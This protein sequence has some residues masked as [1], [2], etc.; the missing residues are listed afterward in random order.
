VSLLAAEAFDF[1][2]RHP[3]DTGFGERLLHFFQFERLYDRLDH[4]HKS[5]FVFDAA[6][7]T[8]P[9]VYALKPLEQPGCQNFA[10]PAKERLIVNLFGILHR[11]GRR[12]DAIKKPYLPSN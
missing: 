9:N 8:A 7:K 12:T 3:L 4:L 10:A 5:S 2:H 11:A 6:D 1:F